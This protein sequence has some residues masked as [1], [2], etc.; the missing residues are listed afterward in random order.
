MLKNLAPEIA[1]GEITTPRRRGRPPELTSDGIVAAARRQLGK[2]G[3]P[4][5]LN[6]RG[7]AA[8]L[9]VTAM[10]LYRY[11]T[12]KDDLLEQVAGTLLDELSLPLLPKRGSWKRWFSEVNMDLYDLITASPIVAHVYATRPVTVVPAMRRMEAALTVLVR[13]GFSEMRSLEIYTAIHAFTIGS[14]TIAASRRRYEPIGRAKAQHHWRSVYES[15]PVDRF[16]ILTRIA[17]DLAELTSRG[18]YEQGL[19][20]MLAQFA[21]RVV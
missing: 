16:P 14:A 5:S 2:S 6:L 13:A 17:P 15:L 9:G 3:T 1:V 4:E 18:T 19:D 11:F 7:V 10:A 12:D 21:N 8:E 20:R